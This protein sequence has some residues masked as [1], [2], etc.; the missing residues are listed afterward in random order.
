MPIT[1]QLESKKKRKGIKGGPSPFSFTAENHDKGGSSYSL[2][3][4][5][6]THTARERETR[7]KGREQ[8]MV[9]DGDGGTT[10][11]MVRVLDAVVELGRLVGYRGGRARL[12]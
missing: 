8:G 9:V 12:G 4:P 11:T 7:G 10:T 3:S 1:D 2:R 5:I 6:T